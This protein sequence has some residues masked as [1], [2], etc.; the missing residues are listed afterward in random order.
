MY[1]LK[2]NVLKFSCVA[3]YSNKTKWF[4]TVIISNKH[5]VLFTSIIND[6]QIKIKCS[7]QFQLILM[8]GSSN[9][10]SF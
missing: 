3:H 1:Y 10:M 4:K 8:R 9:Q 5:Y 6:H 7:F 2:E